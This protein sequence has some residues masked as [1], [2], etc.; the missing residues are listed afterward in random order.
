MQIN[1]KPCAWVLALVIG[2]GIIGGATR[3]M[4]FPAM[5]AA[6]A[7]QDYSKNSKYQQGQREG[8]DDKAHNRDH[9]RKRH[10][11]KDEFFQIPAHAYI[12][13]R[14]V[15]GIAKG[16]RQKRFSSVAVYPGHALPLFPPGHR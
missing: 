8:R 11:S 2:T 1:I 4:G 16:C 6:G 14:R 3:T 12:R 9:F 10:F 13:S 5:N 7:D 15:G